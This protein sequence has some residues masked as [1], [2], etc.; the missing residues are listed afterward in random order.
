VRCAWRSAQ[1]PPVAST[2]STAAGTWPAASSASNR[3]LRRTGRLHGRRPGGRPP[4]GPPARAGGG[5]PHD[6]VWTGSPSRSVGDIR[7]PLARRSRPR[8][9]DPVV[10]GPAAYQKLRRREVDEIGRR[11]ALSAPSQDALQELAKVPG[12]WRA[13]RQTPSCGRWPTRRRGP[14]RRGATP[15]TRDPLLLIRGP[16]RREERAPRDPGGTGGDEAALFRRRH[17]RMYQRYAERQ[18][19]K[20]DVVSISRSGQGGIKE[21]I[22]MVE[23]ARVYSKLRFESGV[24]RV[25]RVPVTEASGRIHTSAI[26][27]PSSGGRGGRRPDRPARTS[28]STPSARPAPAARAS[29]P[30]SSRCGSHS[31]EHRGL[32]PGREEPDQEPREGHEGPAGAPL[33]SGPRRGSR[34]RSRSDRKSQVG[35]GDRSEKI[36]TYTS[37]RRGSPTTG[38]A[39][40]P[41]PPGDP[42]RRPRGDRLR[43]H[44][45][46][47][48]A[49]LKA[50]TAA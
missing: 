12:D 50:S 1:L 2:G 21:V 41:P 7:G 39:S 27:W 30:P 34:R 16:Q 23:G 24:H 45:H 17:L 31:H 11:R 25:Q 26:P 29:T 6:R 14:S 40:H 46:R 15:S 48:A 20:V 36:R 42:R 10:A 33:R 22:A 18:G 37:S 43:P 44:R 38:S 9:P 3:K 35:S 28:G 8:L 19:W 47:Q 5:P 32:L 4:P 49:K 13:S